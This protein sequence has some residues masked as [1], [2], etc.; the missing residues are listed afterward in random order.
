MSAGDVM[1][2]GNHRIFQ[3]FYD[4]E[5]RASLDPGFLPL[6]NR[7]NPRPDW[8]EVWPILRYFE[9]HGIDDACWYGFLSPR[10]HQKT[11]LRSEQIH[12][13]LD[14]YADG[15]DVIV[16]SQRLKRRYR[17]VFEQGERTHPG[18]TAVAQRAFTE[19]GLDVDLQRLD[20]RGRKAVF[21]HYFVA[22][23]AF[24]RRWLEVV[25]KLVALAESGDSVAGAEL[26]HGTSYRA[27]TPPIHYKVFVAERVPSV[28]LG[29]EEGWRVVVKRPVLLR[30]LLP[31]WLR[32]YFEPSRQAS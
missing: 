27:D 15:A 1:V 18:I 24:W 22:R 10:F 28:L 6:D 16:F 13:W 32:K 30:K 17:N 29:I 9:E 31:R 14:R 25:R 3:I 4:D 2:E 11:H 19:M 8:Y 12:R 20:T 26:R 5:T 7:A 21:S 23:G